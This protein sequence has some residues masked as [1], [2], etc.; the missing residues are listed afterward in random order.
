MVYFALPTCA[1]VSQLNLTFCVDPWV[2]YPAHY[3]RGQVTPNAYLSLL[4]LDLRT[5]H[6][7]YAGTQNLATPIPPPLP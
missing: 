3:W 7:F 4:R 2:I 6:P 5:A 1:R